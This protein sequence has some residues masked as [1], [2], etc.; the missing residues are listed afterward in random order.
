MTLMD[1]TSVHALNIWAEH[2]DRVV[3]D[4][5]GHICRDGSKHRPAQA[6][7]ARRRAAGVRRAQPFRTTEGGSLFGDLD[8]TEWRAFMEA[9]EAG[10]QQAL[11]EG[12]WKQ[13]AATGKVGGGL[14]VSCPRF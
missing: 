11:Q 9:L 4:G 7:K 2:E 6:R 3:S 8:E 12:R 10:L 5:K 13:S 14:G 1:Y